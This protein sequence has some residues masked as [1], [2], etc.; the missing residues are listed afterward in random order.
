MGCVYALPSLYKENF[1]VSIQT[2][3]RYNKKPDH[4]VLHEIKNILNE[5][6]I[7]SQSIS[8][9]KES[10]EIF[11]FSELDQLAIYKK[12]SSI[13]L[14]K[15]LISFKKASYI[16][17][18]LCWIKARPIQLGL[19]LKG[20]LYLILRVDILSVLHKFQEQY[21][22]AIQ[23]KLHENKILY[24][25]IRKIKNYDIEIIFKNSDYLS[26]SIIFLSTLD[27]NIL[28]YRIVD[29]CT[30]H[31]TFTKSY[32]NSVYEDIIKKNSIVLQHRMRQLKIFEPV[33]QRYGHDCIAVELPGVQDI[34]AVKSI[35]SNTTNL[36][37]R[38]VNT[39]KNIFDINNNLI[40]EDSEI[41]IDNNGKIIPLYKNII[42]TGEHIINSDINF[43][44]Y[45]RP[46]VNVYLDD[47]G[48][49]I[50]SKFTQDNIGKLIATV[51]IEYKDSGNKDSQGFPILYKH[52]KVIN[53][54]V[55]QSQLTHN[56]C[57]SGIN[58]LHEARY[59][60]FLLKMGSL[61][62][63]VHVEEERII[64]PTLGKKNIT[65]G[66]I[67]CG[68]GVLLSI[69]FMIIWYRYFGCIAGI[70]LM[71]NLILIISIMSIIPGITLTMSSIAGIV[72][73]LSV[74]I[75]ANVLINERIKE[76][77][78]QGKPIQYA[79][80]MGYR[81]AFSSIVD[82]N[83]TTIITSIIL[84]IMGTDPIKGFAMTTIIGVG[85]SMFTSII[86]T[87]VFVNIIYG[88]KKYI[89][90]LSI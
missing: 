3:L 78:Q 50:I 60:S 7:T 1:V 58:N 74:A 28:L 82:S 70:A 41:K 16:P 66:I 61:Y 30:I 25:A 31:I 89:H 34:T 6:N 77:I 46:Q 65:Q 33:I 19:D 59:L 15:Y 4:T 62:S 47:Y 54:A 45:H 52:D 36:E 79:I 56:F 21:I 72:L 14:G 75:D 8:M 43:D 9:Q 18:W 23:S 11:F 22:S 71:I 20:G 39:N 49:S 68:L 76:E 85:T 51:F 55:I 12:L 24:I 84:Y 73:T 90:K 81:K 42:L 27:T 69:C 38:L 44:E 2:D 13:F 37:L 63:P 17:N 10:I 5:E 86:G 53:V 40:A 80:Y 88:K 35:L 83:M 29:A 64:G 32:I 48:S 67:A 87:R 57:I 26:Q